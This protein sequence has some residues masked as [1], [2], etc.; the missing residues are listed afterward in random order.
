MNRLLLI[1]M[2]LCLTGCLIGCTTSKE[3]T[4]PTDC[5]T[6]GYIYGKNGVWQ[7][8]CVLPENTIYADDTA[9]LNVMY[10]LLIVEYAKGTLTDE[11]LQEFA[12][13]VEHYENEGNYEY[14]VA[15]NELQILIEYLKEQRESE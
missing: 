9:S 12:E 14:M 13:S 4:R 11:R 2:A 3:D 1:I 7:E 8:V 15:L 6:T 5:E 10:D